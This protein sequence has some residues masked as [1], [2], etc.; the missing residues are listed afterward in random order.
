MTIV[1]TLKSICEL[2]PS[3]SSENTPAMQQRG[4]LIRHV[5][6]DQFRALEDKLSD[7]LGPY[8]AEFDVEASDGIGRKTEAPWIRIFSRSMSPAP[9]SG[10]YVVVHFARDGTGV[11]VTVGC[12]STI[13]KGGDLVAESDEALK[14]RTDWGR[15]V[16]LEHFGTLA[17]F[18]DQMSLGAKAPLPRTFEKATCVAKRLS[19]ETLQ[20]REFVNL[21]VGATE[22]LREIYEAQRI[23]RDVT[24]ADIDAE[25]VD[26][27]ANPARPKRAGQGL[28]LSAEERRAIELRAMD[29]ART[30]L[31]KEGYKVTDRSKNRSYDFDA[32]G[33]AAK[34]KIEVKGTT[35]D[36]DDEIFM[37]KNEVEL[38]RKERGSTGLIIVSKIRLDRA[39]GV[40]TATGG[41]L[42]ADIG[43]NVDEWY[44]APM[45]YRVSRKPILASNLAGAE[46]LA[47]LDE[48]A[49][50][51]K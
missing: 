10:F 32:V 25:E 8:A 27:A 24:P 1:E 38:H 30:W 9:T 6:R 41:H 36:P 28:R 48:S 17:P 29:V 5:L 12:G 46:E 47:D 16:I 34:L 45:A 39:D 18:T 23:G 7:A 40:V 11:Y 31:Q 43:W 13:W 2:Q 51:V 22:R 42:R 49:D 15:G 19:P 50:S 37:T 26:T 3:Y 4:H 33:A 14:Q 20:E 21:L 44:L 35:S